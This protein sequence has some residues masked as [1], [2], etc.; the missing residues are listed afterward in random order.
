MDVLLL[1]DIA[2]VGKKNDLLAVGN[3]FALNYLLPRRLAIVAT[4]IVRRLYAEAIKHRME[5]K[6]QEKALQTGAAA[7]LAGK[8]ITFTKKATKTG[9]IYAAISE[10]AISTALKEQLQLD[11]PP[12]SITIPSPIKALGTFEVHIQ[13]GETELP[14]AVTVTAESSPQGKS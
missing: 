4:P 9:K 14:L 1:Q 11:I 6:E 8:S 5:E 3:G 2:R 10:K 7:A 12:E 13:L